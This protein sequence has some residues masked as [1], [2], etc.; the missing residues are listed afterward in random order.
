MQCSLWTKALCWSNSENL[1]E[2]KT[3]Y[4]LIFS[5]KA[6]HP[7]N[8]SRP[9]NYLWILRKTEKKTGYYLQSCMHS[10]KQTD[11]ART[12]ELLLR[13]KPIPGTVSLCA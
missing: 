4:S 8:V 9:M 1:R 5:L 11:K 7:L 13:A 3:K 6:R 2:M 10:I 12:S